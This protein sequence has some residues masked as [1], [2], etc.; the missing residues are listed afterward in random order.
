MGMSK[1]DEIR[2]RGK[3]ERDAVKLAEQYAVT[4]DYAEAARWYQAAQIHRAVREALEGEP[5]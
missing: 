5:R 1:K 2:Q 4:K 3:W